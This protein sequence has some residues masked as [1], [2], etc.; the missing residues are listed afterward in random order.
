MIHDR[1]KMHFAWTLSQE[2][3]ARAMASLYDER[4]HTLAVIHS[5]FRR[6]QIEALRTQDR[7][8]LEA[9]RGT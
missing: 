4:T 6:A 9:L 3:G 2:I 1:N 5:R 8:L 7:E